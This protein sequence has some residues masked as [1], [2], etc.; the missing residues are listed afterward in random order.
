MLLALLLGGHELPGR[1]RHPDRAGRCADGAHGAALGVALLRRASPGHAG[2]LG[3]PARPQVVA[4]VVLTILIRPD[5]RALKQGCRYALRP[6]LGGDCGARPLALGAVL[7]RHERSERDLAFTVL[8]VTVLSTV[9]MG[10]AT[11]AVDLFGGTTG[12]GGGVFLASPSMTSHERRGTARQT[13]ATTAV[14][15]LMNSAA[16]L[17]GAY[18]AWDPARARCDREIGAERSPLLYSLASLRV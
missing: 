1:G 18:A 13:A 11:G 14:Y 17:V 4:G 15:N 7:P 12:T 3:G 16:A 2:V 8:S 6:R 10:F 9:A 5:R